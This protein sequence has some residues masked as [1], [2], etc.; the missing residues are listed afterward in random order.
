MRW[1]LGAVLLLAAALRLGGLH[2]DAH[3]WEAP[4][5]PVVLEE[6]HLHPVGRRLHAVRTIYT[7]PDVESVLG[8][9]RRYEVGYVYVG[10]LERLYYGGP[11][12]DKFESAPAHFERVFEN[13][14]VRIYRFLGHLDD[15]Q[16]RVP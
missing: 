1:A 15:R 13:S 5:R 4:G 10:P 11:G 9:L 7:A 3:R 6:Q 16:P 14:G 2:W 12:L 8:L